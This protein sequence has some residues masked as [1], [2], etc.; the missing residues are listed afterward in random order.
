LAQVVSQDSLVLQRRKWKDTRR[1]VVFV[2]GC[3]D[4]LHPG[5]IRLLEQARSYGD[6]LVVGVQSDVGVRSAHSRVNSAKGA[7]ALFA[8]ESMRPITPAIERVE[9]LAALAALD[10]VVE[11]D[12]PSPDELVVRLAPDIIVKGASARSGSA[13]STA[14]GVAESLGFKTVCIPLEPGYSTTSLI[15]RISQAGA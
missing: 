6:I 14:D 10:Y 3:F 8:E 11:F 4:L 13:D 7:A 5:H 15:E 2:G 9:I 12:E 1:S